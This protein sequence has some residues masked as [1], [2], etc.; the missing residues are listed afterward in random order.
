M[1]LVSRK[2]SA[3]PQDLLD[4]LRIAQQDHAVA[5][6]QANDLLVAQH[7]AILEHAQNRTQTIDE[8]LRLLKGERD[9]LE[10]VVLAAAQ[11]KQAGQ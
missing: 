10:P 8:Q 11:P 4:K 6:S 2:P 9:A 3:S 1:S 5:V 7:D